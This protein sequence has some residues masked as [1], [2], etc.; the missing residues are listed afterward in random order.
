M[1]LAKQDHQD[2]RAESA[3]ALHEA[4]AGISEVQLH[5]E[6]ARDLLSINYMKQ[7]CGGWVEGEEGEL[8][9]FRRAGASQ[10]TSAL[11]HTG[12]CLPTCFHSPLSH[13]AM[14]VFTQRRSSAGGMRCAQMPPLLRP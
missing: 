8:V 12:R 10:P 4:L 3:Q 2:F 11:Y 7:V 6:D 14:P 9:G 13:R 1:A 5:V